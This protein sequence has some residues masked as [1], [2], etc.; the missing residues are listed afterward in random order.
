MKNILLI[1]LGLIILAG[2]KKSSNDEFNQANQNAAEKYIKRIE[3]TSDS[4]SKIIIINYDSQ[5][6]IS[7]VT[8]GESS[9]FPSYDQGNGSLSSVENEDETMNISDLYEAPYDAFETGT[10]LQYDAN[11]NPVKLEVFE[12]GYDSEVLTGE[13][14]YDAAPNPFFYTLKAA[15]IIDVLDRVELNFGQQQSPAIIKARKL[16]PYNNIKSMVFKDN[17]GNTRCEIQAD[18]IYNSDK[19]PESATITYLTSDETNITTVRYY[20]R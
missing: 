7:S 10:V 5:G 1:A 16:L 20:Y 9:G 6:N 19:Y 11:N 15:K 3:I 8:D 17:E 13:I 14:S 4:E 12:D 18:Y 2:C